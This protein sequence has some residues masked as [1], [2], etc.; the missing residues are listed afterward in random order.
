MENKQPADTVAEQPANDQEQPANDQ[1]QPGNNVQESADNVQEQPVDNEAGPAAP[2]NDGAATPSVMLYNGESQ[3]VHVNVK[4]GKTADPLDAELQTDVTLS[5]GGTQEELEAYVLFVLDKSTSTDVRDEA[6]VMLDELMKQV[7]A[8]YSINVGVIS[9]EREVDDLLNGW[10][11]LNK[12]GYQQI[13]DALNTKRDESGTNIYLGL[14][15]AKAKM[16]A[17]TEVDAAYKHIVLVTDGI[18]YLW[19]NSEDTSDTKLYSIYSESISHTEESIN[20]GMDMIVKHHPDNY[21]AFVAEFAD[22][23]TWMQTYGDAVAKDIATY[24]HVYG[25]G[26]YKPDVQGQR[27]NSTYNNAGFDE[28]DYIPGESLTDHYSANEAAVYMATTVWQEIVNAGYHAYAYADVTGESNS[29]NAAKNPWAAN[30]ISGLGTIGGNTGRVT[31]DAVDGMF[32]DVKSS[33]IYAID[34]GTVTDVIGKDFDLK[35]AEKFEDSFTLTVGG[36]EQTATS[37]GGNIVNFGTAS[38]GV[39]PYVVTYYPDGVN[40]DTQEQFVWQINTPVQN[41]APLQLTYKV[42]LVNVPTVIGEYKLPTNEEA[43]L[44][45]TSTN[46]GTGSEEFTK[47][48]VTY[49]VVGV[50]PASLTIYMGGSSGYGNIVGEDG[51]TLS[52]TVSLPE[53]GFYLELTEDMNKELRAVLGKEPTD[54]IDLSDYVTLTNGKTTWNLQRYG[55]VDGTE[56]D[57]ET[58]A[59]YIEGESRF[60]YKIVPEDGKM[61]TRERRYASK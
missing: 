18:T 55:Y 8:G 3:E 33:I 34:H 20:A 23:K 5:I 15:E 59:G 27:D 42:K 24:Q 39:Y 1:E 2:S 26:Q 57:E 29:A 7:N 19:S 6:A 12:D 25:A 45:Y 22:M 30:F 38:D 14:R 50:T 49:N 60:I 52:N 32:D 58:S 28:G 44:D 46:G 40:G 37:G 17:L 31:T 47:P 11:E 41:I 51:Q 54:I 36:V 35:V 4:V 43:T 9:F 16:D 48:K 53:P 56:A 61:V 10:M 21:D 13:V